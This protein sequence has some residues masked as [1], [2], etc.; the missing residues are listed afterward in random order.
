MA[1]ET[2]SQRDIRVGCEYPYDGRTPKDWADKAALGILRDLSDRRGIKHEL[3][4]VDDDVR[5]DIVDA[6]AEII[7]VAKSD[8]TLEEPK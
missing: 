6:M 5:P 1:E 4:A 7:R 3:G 8:S 2:K